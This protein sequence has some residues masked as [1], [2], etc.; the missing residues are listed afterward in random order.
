MGIRQLV[1]ASRGLEALVWGTL[2]S[3]GLTLAKVGDGGKS[4][5]RLPINGRTC[6]VT[7]ITARK[8]FSHYT[9]YNLM[10]EGTDVMCED[11]D[12]G[13]TTIYSLSIPHDKPP[14]TERD[15]RQLALFTKAVLDGGWWLEVDGLHTSWHETFRRDLLFEGQPLIASIAHTRP[16]YVSN[17]YKFHLFLFQD[18]KLIG[19]LQDKGFNWL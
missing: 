18:G 12:M 1:A 11:I 9:N 16:I 8:P 13:D 7:L 14:S 19:Q 2:V 5:G 4:F 3:L 6:N 10:I 17:D 15:F